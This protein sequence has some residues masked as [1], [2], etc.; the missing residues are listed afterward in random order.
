MLKKNSKGGKKLSKERN[1]WMKEGNGGRKKKIKE[2]EWWKKAGWKG[3]KETVILPTSTNAVDFYEPLCLLHQLC[4]IL[5]NLQFNSIVS[6]LCCPAFS[7]VFIPMKT[8]ISPTHIY[9]IFTKNATQKIF[10][11]HSCLQI[12]S[13]S[14]Q[15]TNQHATL[16]K[17]HPAPTQSLTSESRQAFTIYEWKYHWKKWV[18]LY[19][20]V[21]CENVRENLE[22]RVEGR[23]S[24]VCEQ[25]STFSYFYRPQTKLREGYVFTGVSFCSQGD[26]IPT[27]I[28]GGIT[29]CLAAGSACSQG[30]CSRGG[31]CS[32]R[33][34]W[35]GGSAPGGLLQGGS[36]PGGVPGA[37]PPGTA[38]AA[39]G[40]HPT[41]MHSCRLDF[42]SNLSN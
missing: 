19:Y 22:H 36:A 26:G 34:A 4:N 18:T 40:T 1:E 33:G 35:S 29:A 13:P 28:A 21:Q 5:I 24:C 10:F 30:V 6:S 42:L 16:E 31:V 11:L 20:R 39:G 37:D 17:C 15:S 14:F 27:C 7:S 2:G 41:G 12:I 8:P 25:E 38:T 32:R 3:M 9:I 23:P